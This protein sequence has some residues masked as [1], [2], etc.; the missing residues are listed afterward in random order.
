MTSV[1]ISENPTSLR[2]GHNLCCGTMHFNGE[3]MRTSVNLML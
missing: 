2:K 3:N 1:F